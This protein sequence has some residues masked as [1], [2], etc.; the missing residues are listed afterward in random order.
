M[1]P[2]VQLTRRTGST[3]FCQMLLMLKVHDL[4]HQRDL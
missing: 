2:P 3:G 4:R 1:F